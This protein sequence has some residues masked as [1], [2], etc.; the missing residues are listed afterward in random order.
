MT[1]KNIFRT[2]VLIE[3]PIGEA[4]EQLMNKIKANQNLYT[5]FRAS[6][7]YKELDDEIEKFEQ[8]KRDQ[9]NKY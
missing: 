9:G 1:E 5:R 2:Y 8:W 3:M 6:Q 4:N 7:A